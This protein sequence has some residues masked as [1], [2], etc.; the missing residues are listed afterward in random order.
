MFI[1]SDYIAKLFDY[2][3]DDRDEIVSLI[4]GFPHFLGSFS[5]LL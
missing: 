5:S 4:G 2:Y 1:A 3:V